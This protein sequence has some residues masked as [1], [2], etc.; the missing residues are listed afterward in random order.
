MLMPQ[1]K[2]QKAS[3][4]FVSHQAADCERSGDYC[5]AANLWRVAASVTKNRLNWQYCQD[6]AEFCAAW[7]YRIGGNDAP[8]STDI[9]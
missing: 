8:V 7:Q 9:R 2:M 5:Q 1:T 3:Y 6:R 4:R